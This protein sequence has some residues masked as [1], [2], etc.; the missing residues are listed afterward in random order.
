[1][2]QMT[3]TESIFSLADARVTAHISLGTMWIREV[4]HFD[5]EVQ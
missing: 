3:P 4:S 2:S 1:M 5:M